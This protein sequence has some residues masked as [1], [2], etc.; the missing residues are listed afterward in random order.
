[1]KTLMKQF[2]LISILSI[3][4]SSCSKD[5]DDFQKEAS[6][7]ELLIGKWHFNILSTGEAT[8]CE[9]HT[10]Y[11][12][13]DSETATFKLVQD[14]TGILPAGAEVIGDC[15]F[16]TEETTTYTLVNNQDIKIVNE[17]GIATLKIVS[18]NTTTLIITRDALTSV[19]TLVLIKEI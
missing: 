5:D 18:I 16:S 14:D 8:E 15:A 2:V 13:I 10:F 3:S 1:M 19:E 9:A 7:Q 17:Y 4:L 12:F 6:V 11:H